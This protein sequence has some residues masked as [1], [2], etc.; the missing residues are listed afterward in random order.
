[1]LE[2]IRRHLEHTEQLQS[3]NEKLPKNKEVWVK[4]GRPAE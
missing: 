4:V 1:V 2:W 3:F